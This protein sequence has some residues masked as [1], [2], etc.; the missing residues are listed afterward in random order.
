M[1]LV[2][3]FKNKRAE[4]A[5]KH[6]CSFNKLNLILADENLEILTK[7]IDG[8]ALLMKTLMQHS[9]ESKVVKKAC[10]ALSSLIEPEG[11]TY[12]I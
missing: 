5:R 1:T 7:D 8:V 2:I 3:W 6:N 10:L 4:I 11:K 9:N 12:A